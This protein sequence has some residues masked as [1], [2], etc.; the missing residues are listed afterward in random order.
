MENGNRLNR[1]KLEELKIGPY[2]ILEKISNSI[3]KI[4]TGYKK[5]ESNLFHITKLIPVPVE[6]WKARGGDVN[7]ALL[8]LH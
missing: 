7:E 6:F 5:L 8:A 3:Y 1:K 4:N 2:K